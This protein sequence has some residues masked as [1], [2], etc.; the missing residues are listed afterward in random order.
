MGAYL[1]TGLVLIAYAVLVW[2]L[3]SWLHMQGGLL[4]LLRSLLWLIGCIGASSF[5]Y[6]F[7]KNTKLASA[8]TAGPEIDRLVELALARF[9]HGTETKSGLSGESVVLVLGPSGSTKTSIL[10]NAE[11]DIELLSG[12]IGQDGNIPPTSSLNLFYTPQAIFADVGAPL[13]EQ[14]GAVKRLLGRLQPNDLMRAISRGQSAPRSVI[15]CFGCDD[16]QAGT[17]AAAAAAARM[18]AILR[19]VAEVLGSDFPV[20]VV[21]TKLDRVRGFTEYVDGL[22]RDEAT[23][24]LGATLPLRRS[25]I[26]AYVGEENT[27]LSNAFDELVCSLAEKR[28]EFL[29]RE[30][31]AAKYGAIYEF[32]RELRKLRTSIL[33]FLMDVC[34]PTQVAN[35]PFLRG[36]YFC[37]VRPIFVQEVTAAA[38]TAP[39][40]EDDRGATRMFTADQ[41]AAAV[42][43]ALEP[44]TKTKKVPQWAFLP[45]IISNIV[46]RDR[47]AL[48]AAGSS[49]AVGLI[50]RALLSAAS[51]AIL[52]WIGLT[53][54]SF[55]ENRA[56]QQN[57][58]QALA[59]LPDQP[60]DA[61]PSPASLQK[62]DQVRQALT[63][64]ERYQ[65]QG[66]PWHMHLGLYVGDS[67]Y[68]EARR[69]YFSRF[70]AMLLN[71]T[72]ASLLGTLRSLPETTDPSRDYSTTYSA[73][74]TYLITTDHPDK[75]EKPFLPDTLFSNWPP[76]KQ[77][78]AASAAIAQAQFAYYADALAG[79]DPPLLTKADDAAVDRARAYLRA[80]GS[81]ERLYQSVLRE[82]AGQAEPLNFNRKFGSAEVLIDS[83]TVPAAF[84]RAGY[85]K[86]QFSFSHLADMLSKEEWVVPARDNAVSASDL[87][88]RLR[89]RYQQEYIDNWRAF[90]KGAHVVEF[91]GYAD[92]AHKLEALANPP[93]PMLA[94]FSMISDNTS[95]TSSEIENQFQPAPVTVPAG[96][97]PMVQGGNQDYL[98]ALAKVAAAL[99]SVTL[100]APGDQAAAAQQAIP[101]VTAGSVAPREI[102]QKFEPDQ[103]NH[104]A[105]MSFALLQ[106][107]FQ[108]AEDVL[109]SGPVGQL[110]A[111]GQV[112]CSSISGL[113]NKFPFNPG[114]LEEASVDEVSA[115][116]APG[117]MMTDFYNRYLQ[118]YVVR[119][120]SQYGA[121]PG[122]GVKINAG[123]VQW[124]NSMTAFQAAFYAGGSD[125][126]RLTFSLASSPKN[127]L[128]DLVATIGSDKLSGSG[129]PR[130]FTWIPGGPGLKFTAAGVNQE[131]RGQWALFHFA[132]DAEWQ[133]ANGAPELRLP[134]PA[135]GRQYLY[136]DLGG[137]ANPFVLDKPHM[138][139]MRNC[140]PTVA[141][142]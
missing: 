39:P 38:P 16:L 17:Q 97:S 85:D 49:S 122:G 95:G 65:Q 78:D 93:Y 126:P 89:S 81:E 54:V 120:G 36:F 112:F 109:R 53:A 13:L 7:R 87:E 117:K 110:N 67:F 43:P 108:H 26:A 8:G 19:E 82:A 127:R 133:S 3:G 104:T 55:V 48:A 31:D 50:R 130:T 118:K 33:Q 35:A 142:R 115:V 68:P 34:R 137:M 40:P 57:V 105:A 91:A 106:Q 135:G 11:L 138:A 51:L 131:Y 29:A 28:T 100:A 60:S 79:N 70:D 98:G 119:V 63:N 139:M 56:L 2:L 62:L 83:V 123:F 80:L 101:T 12:D 125:Q 77:L 6:F 41:V 88:A 129:E 69:A 22:S 61:P 71:S 30:T 9:Q 73:L 15:V 44:V 90:L 124:F 134:V 72:R 128:S 121:V 75:S 64:L 86:A 111:A 25:G 37:G 92:A 21:F 23:Q 76:G 52:A 10:Q 32:P 84:T 27:R 18:N 113:M 116:F 136:F 66:A 24:V 102:A 4:W 107:P 5:I 42:S 114:A 94:L 140:V 59:E 74:K 132:D 47:T 14:P 46:L 103:L 141:R 99:K 20:Y 45:H 96:A 1:I 58:V